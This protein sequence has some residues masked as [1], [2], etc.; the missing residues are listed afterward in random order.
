MND[1]TMPPSLQ[2]RQQT[3]K[4]R[5]IKS[6]H[7]ILVSYKVYPPPKPSHIDLGVS[8]S[9]GGFKNGNQSLT[10]TAIGGGGDNPPISRS[11]S[12][13]RSRLER[14]LSSDL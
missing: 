13:S 1:D 6:C 2:L 14:S 4:P 10:A 7:I 5:G 3:K 9:S 8:S 12:R 11:S